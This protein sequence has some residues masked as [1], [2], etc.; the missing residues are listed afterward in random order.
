M[1]VFEIIFLVQNAS[2]ITVQHFG[3]ILKFQIF[4]FL[5]LQISIVLVRNYQNMSSSLSLVIGI[6]PACLIKKLR[7]LFCNKGFD[8]EKRF[9]IWQ[10]F[11]CFQYLLCC[12]FHGWT[13]IF[14]MRV[15]GTVF[16]C[17][18]WIEIVIFYY[19]ARTG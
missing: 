18:W 13:Y 7:V 2:C 19:H 10:F 9:S 15:W 12:L 17:W 8:L 4:F 6:S 3:S 1:E 5:I 16:F 14:Y 11:G